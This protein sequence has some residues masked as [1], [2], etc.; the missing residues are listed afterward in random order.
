MKKIVALFLTLCLALPVFASCS[1]TLTETETGA[2]A[3]AAETKTAEE[4]AGQTETGA[5]R[6]VSKPMAERPNYA[7]RE[8]ATPD[9]MRETAIR[10]QHDEVTVLWYTD[11]D[12][13]YGK[14]GAGEGKTFQYTPY[15]TYGGLPYTNGAVSLFHWLEYYDFETGRMVDLPSGEALNATLGNSCAASV[16]WGWSSVAN[17]FTWYTTMGMNVAH[18]AIRVGPYTY[19]DGITSYLNYPTGDICKENG[20]Q[21][22]FESYAAM[23]KADALVTCGNSPSG[24]GMMA[25]TEPVVVRGADG[26]INGSES[27]IVIQEQTSGIFQTSSD[28]IKVEDGERHHYIGRSYRKTTFASLFKS[29]Y[30]PHTCAEFLGRK[31]YDVPAAAFTGDVTTL[32]ELQSATIHSAQKICVVRLDFYDESG[33]LVYTRKGMTT[34]NDLSQKTV[35]DYPLSRMSI[36]RSALGRSLTKGSHYTVKVSVLDATGTT[37]EVGSLSFTL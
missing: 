20:E 21:V 37:L 19:D 22:M 4:T 17:S 28:Y 26:K 24:H 6:S 3:T 33:T 11:T 32:E 1:S 25:I 18:G 8:G 34:N 9:E 7:L 23:H 2:P 16:M 13:I 30:L 15:E 27:Y 12:I 5:V 31:P 35:F 36:S 10:A 14:S 29:G